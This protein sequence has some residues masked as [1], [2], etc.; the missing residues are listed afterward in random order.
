MEGH[1]NLTFACFKHQ[2]ARWLYPTSGT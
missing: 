1:L 2:T